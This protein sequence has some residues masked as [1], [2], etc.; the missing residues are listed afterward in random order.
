[1]NVESEPLSESLFSFLAPIKPFK[2]PDM[3]HKPRSWTGMW[4]AKHY[5]GLSQSL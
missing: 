3:P 5:K 2:S 1:M 4:I